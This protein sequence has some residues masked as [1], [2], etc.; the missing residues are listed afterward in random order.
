M[1]VARVRADFPALART[2]HGRPLTYLDTA[3]SAQK[4]TIVLEA[5]DEFYR[6]HYANVHRGVYALSEEAT[7]LYEGARGT[8][9]RFLHAKDPDEVVFTRGTTESINLVAASLGRLC[10]ERG[11]HVLATVMEHHSNL[12]PWHMLR[13]ERGIALDYLDIDA[14][15]RLEL[16]RLKEQITPRTR[17]VTLTHASNVLG[18]VNPIREITAIAHERGAIVVL[19]AAQTAAHH[20]IDVEALGIDFLAFSGHKTMGPTG[21]GVLWGRKERLEALPPFLGGGDMIREVHLD[22]VL[23]RE[24]PAR[25]EAGTPNIAGAIGLGA[26]LRYIESLGWEAIEE[27]EQ[28]LTVHGLRAA[29]EIQGDA[30]RIYGPSEASSRDATFSFSL[31]GTHPHDVASLLDAEGIAIR[32]GHHCAQPLME[33]LG[34]SALSRASAAVYNTPEELDRLFQ[35]L[36]KVR[37]LFD[38]SPR[39]KP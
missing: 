28:R 24:P 39:A 6:V 15:G 32:S 36:T 22:R 23:Y 31:R 26:A 37:A 4:P 13:E 7:D 12:V 1:D 10:L 17:V 20:P 33:R 25:F 34:V 14:D 5:M 3:S 30:V 19:D 16:E 8:V 21:I 35:A 18:T 29:R 9:T 11:D 38:G 27:H 2:V